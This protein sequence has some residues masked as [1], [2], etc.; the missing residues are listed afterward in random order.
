MNISIEQLDTVLN[1]PSI[2]L[3]CSEMGDDTFDRSRKF[4][5][6]G[7]KYEIIWYVNEC[8]LYHENM[9]VPFDYVI[10]SGTF[11]NQSIMNLQF[12]RGK[13]SYPICIIGLINIKT[14]GE[15]S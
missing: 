3:L 11:P 15:Q 14:L 4:V 1:H 8:T 2:S 9:I 7:K 10:Q 6:D 5:I 13:D 12:Y